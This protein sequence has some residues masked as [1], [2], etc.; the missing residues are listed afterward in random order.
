MSAAIRRDSSESRI[1]VDK[2]AFPQPITQVLIVCNPYFQSRIS[3]CPPFLCTLRLLTISPS[4]TIWHRNAYS[5]TITTTSG[6][7]T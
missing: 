5:T 3:K 4:L 1:D 7:I 6:T 2:L